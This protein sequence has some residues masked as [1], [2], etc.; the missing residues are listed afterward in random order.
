MFT[1]RVPREQLL[2]SLKSNRETHRSDFLEALEGYQ[3]FAE[4]Q[5]AK[6]LEQARSNTP[7]KI[8]SNFRF[9]VPQDHTEEYD[10]AIAMV[11]MADTDLIAIG[12]EEFSHYVQDDWSWKRQFAA[13]TDNYKN[14]K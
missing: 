9:D 6:W 1:V 13:T 7:D 3:K 2:S 10:R 12:E 11:T 14:Y 4:A 8:T 5:F